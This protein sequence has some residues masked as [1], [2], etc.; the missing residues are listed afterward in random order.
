MT[1]LHLPVITGNLHML[2]API[3]LHGIARV[4]TEGD[5]HLGGG[6][7]TLLLLPTLYEALNAIVGTSIPLSLKL[8]MH[9]FDGAPALTTKFDILLQPYRQLITVEPLAKL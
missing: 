4:K 8:L 3:E 6:T 5:I 2:K 1:N 9:S 7:M